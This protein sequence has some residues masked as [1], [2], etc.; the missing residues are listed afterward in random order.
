[1]NE[2]L[3]ELE[4]IQHLFKNPK[5]TA[6]R[7]EAL[8]ERVKDLEK[9]NESLLLEKAANLQK[10]LR[11]KFTVTE[12][13]NILIE[14]VDLTDANALKTMTYNLE[15]EIGSALIVFGS[16]NQGKP[17]LTVC[18]SQNLV[19]SHKLNASAIVKDLAKAIR[20]GGGGQPTFATAGG[21]FA[22]GLDAALEKAK[23]ILK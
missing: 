18:V 11:T 3:A 8:M 23:A 12:G 14:K 7:V 16:V 22:E 13:V 1:M 9:A 2:K 10:V 4:K 20:G 15:K 19:A 21:T 17:Q 5:D 6:K